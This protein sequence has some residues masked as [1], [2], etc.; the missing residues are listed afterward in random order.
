MMSSDDEAALLNDMKRAN[1]HTSLSMHSWTCP[2]C[3]QEI[4]ANKAQ[5]HILVQEHKTATCKLSPF[6]R[7]EELD[8]QAL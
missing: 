2:D 6:D 4:R 1:S 8:D 7:E 3:Y 5:L